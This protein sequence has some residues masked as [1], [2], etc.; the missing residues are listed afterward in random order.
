MS[1]FASLQ[2]ARTGLDAARAGLTVTG[3]NITNADVHG[4]TRQR[5]ETASVTPTRSMTAFSTG[6]G[7]G[8]GAKIT[9]YVRL[10]DDFLDSQARKAIGN[11]ASART[12]A[13]SFSSVE[14]I[15]GEPTAQGVSS[16]M[17]AMWSSW[18]DVANNP[19]NSAPVS[20]MLEKTSTFADKL[21]TGLSELETQWSHSQ[22][23]LKQGL[24]ETNQLAK[25]LAEINDAIRTTK[26]AG[27]SVNEMLDER[28]RIA[29]EISLRVGGS[30]YEL[31]DGTT[32]YKIGGVALVHGTSARELVLSG[33]T[34]PGDTPKVEW[35]HHPGVAVATGQGAV[36][37][38]LSALAA[39]G[40]I[41]GSHTEYKKFITEIATA[42]NNL[43]NGAST[44]GGGA[45]GDFFSISVDGR[46]NI[47][48]T[49]VDEVGVGTPGN[50]TLDNSIA[51]AISQLGKGNLNSNW[52]TFIGALGAKSKSAITSYELAVATLQGAEARQ[53]SG[54]S[55]DLDE[56]NINLLSY[57]RSY[58]AAANV[59][60]VMSESLELIVNLGR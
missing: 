25:Q 34:V 5:L 49:T 30:M 39:D 38:H 19:G 2:L 4:Y 23:S 18:Q 9:G 22:N 48:P 31:E 42:V 11:A 26:N 10:G 57:Q 16:L 56:E 24:D 17:Q 14:E 52:N 21:N 12:I 50:G 1:T 41:A 59:F 8:Q 37:G 46:L 33:G 20:V 28:S 53:L 47:I 15:T 32:E 36:S 29:S 60:N 7:V 6:T 3:Q 51:D 27:G 43:H 54:A 55:V 58:Q 13:D 40:P 44:P 45:A 35:S